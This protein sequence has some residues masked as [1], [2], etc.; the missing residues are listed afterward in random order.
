[1]HTIKIYN[2]RHLYINVTKLHV[3][4][5]KARALHNNLS[6]RNKIFLIW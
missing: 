1:M 5:S 2:I 6:F 4:K 3:N